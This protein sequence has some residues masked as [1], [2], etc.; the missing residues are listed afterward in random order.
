MI[1]HK[2]LGRGLI[3]IQAHSDECQTLPGIGFLKFLEGG[4][5]VQEGLGL[6]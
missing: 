4:Q 5:V 6:R 2:L 3:F 1:I